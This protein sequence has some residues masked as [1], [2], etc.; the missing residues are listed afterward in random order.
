MAPGRAE[1]DAGR[2]TRVSAIHAARDK[3]TL[4]QVNRFQ[5]IF[6]TSYASQMTNWKNPLSQG[7]RI[8]SAPDRF[9]GTLRRYV[10][11]HLE[12]SLPKAGNALAWHE[13]VLAHAERLNSP[14]LVRMTPGY[15]QEHEAK[16]ASG[17][18][19]RMTDNAPPWWIHAAAFSGIAP[20][21]GGLSE[22]FDYIWCWMFR[23]ANGGSTGPGHANAAGW[24]VAHIL[25]AKPSGDG[26][27]EGWDEAT[28]KQ[29]FLRNLSPLNHFLVPKGNGRDVGERASVIATI[30]DW[31]RSRH[32]TVFEEFLREAGLRPNEI[33][34]PD[35]DLV[36]EAMGSTGLATSIQPSSALRMPS[37]VIPPDLVTPDSSAPN[38]WPLV[39]EGSHTRNPRADILNAAA[40]APDLLAKL[41][42]G[43]TVDEFVGVANALFNKCDPKDLE[44]DAPG[45]LCRQANLAWTHLHSAKTKPNLGGKWAK[46]VSGLRSGSR[47]GLSKLTAM[48]LDGFVNAALRVV[49]KVYRKV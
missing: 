13:A 31:Y 41:L 1:T 44:A 29:R 46:C 37:R 25:C 38:Y 4:F 40:K 49:S 7:P 2:E 34:R 32:G 36:I 26:P 16:S 43:L 17:R 9:F 47:D 39:L 3:G 48:R 10:D 33:G 15:K 14:L 8:P 21:A 45:D 28:A 23:A 6:L 12:P 27:P 19:L 30:A 20:P 18:L 35:W 22:I 42:D 24:Y 11:E 5:S